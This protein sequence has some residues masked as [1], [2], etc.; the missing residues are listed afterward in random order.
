[1]VKLDQRVSRS[2]CFIVS[3]RAS[4]SSFRLVA[5]HL[6]QVRDQ[7]YSAL[8]SPIPYQCGAPHSECLRVCLLDRV[9]CGCES[10]GIDEG[11]R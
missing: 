2:R 11:D 5:P 6:S 1:M 3:P 4:V 9:F 8:I 7:Q 10:V